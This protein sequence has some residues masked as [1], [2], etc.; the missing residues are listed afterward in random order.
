MHLRV[1]YFP[2]LC[3]SACQC[4]L[5]INVPVYQYAN[6]SMYQHRDLTVRQCI[7]LSMYTLVYCLGP[8]KRFQCTVISGSLGSEGFVGLLSGQQHI[9]IRTDCEAEHE[10]RRANGR[11]NFELQQRIIRDAEV[12]RALASGA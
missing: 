4:V 3:V 11:K 5:C 8:S 1:L 12:A 10:Q 2:H 6:V 9:R 7:D